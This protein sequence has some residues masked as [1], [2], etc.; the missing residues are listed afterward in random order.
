MVNKYSDLEIKCKKTLVDIASDIRKIKNHLAC[1]KDI[2]Q[3][4]SHILTELRQDYYYGPGLRNSSD[5]EVG[6]RREEY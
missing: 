3:K 4:I 1:L 6:Y 2:D 5:D